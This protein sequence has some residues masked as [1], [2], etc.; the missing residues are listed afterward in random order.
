[1]GIVY[2]AL[3]EPGLQDTGRRSENCTC[4][5][6]VQEWMNEIVAAKLIDNLADGIAMHQIGSPC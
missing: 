6:F 4:Q 1:M 2:I 5:A 3:I